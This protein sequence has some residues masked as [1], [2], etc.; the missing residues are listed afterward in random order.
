MIS[1]AVV[2]EVKQSTCPRLGTKSEELASTK[3]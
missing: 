2:V 1:V 3:S